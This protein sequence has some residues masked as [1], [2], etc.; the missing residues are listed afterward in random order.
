MLQ[1]V[2]LLSNLFEKDNKEFLLKSLYS[3]CIIAFLQLKPYFQH[4][5]D[6]C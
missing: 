6:P 4:N 1:Y 5:Q 2:T 3:S